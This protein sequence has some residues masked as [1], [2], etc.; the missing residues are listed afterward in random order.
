MDFVDLHSHVLAAL[1]DG[2]RALAESLEMMSLLRKV[3]FS[4][5][6]ATP[7]QRHNMFMPGR[8]EIDRA[9]A[10]LAAALPAGAAELL[11]AA[12]NM[13]D[14]VFLERSLAGAQPGYTGGKAFL[15]ELPVEVMP[16]RLEDRLFA[17]RRAPRRLL[18]VMAHP[19]RYRA[20]WDDAER[21]ARLRTQAALVI[22]LGA[23]DGAHGKSQCKAARAWVEQR[24]VH[25]AASDV[26]GPGDV[27][28]AAAGIAWIR[29]RM[30][31]GEV[32]RLLREG[33]RQILAGEI[34]D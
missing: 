15:F 9:H 11:L 25:A 10:E 29:K 27:R 32:Q 2:A 1:D 8:E 14:E 34:P 30:G 26:H 19:E 16:P 6:V 5:V 20:L 4:T 24:L 21:V 18:P 7:H 28:F 33:P 3:G 12:E 31:E 23:L 22:D 13:W 17:I